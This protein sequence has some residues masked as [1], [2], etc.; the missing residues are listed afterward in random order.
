[1][2]PIAELFAFWQQC[3][4]H[5]KARLDD[6]RARAISKALRWGYEVADLKLAIYGCCSNPW[7]GEG[8]NTNNTIY[9]HI[10]LILRDAD[11]IDRFMRDGQDALAKAERAAREEDERRTTERDRVREI[12]AAARAKVESIFRRR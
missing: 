4:R 6:K 9:T 5:P 3:A 11:H 8:R 12:P 2:S 10:G 7:Y 1:M